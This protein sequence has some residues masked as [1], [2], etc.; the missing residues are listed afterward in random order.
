[1]TG[2]FMTDEEAKFC[3]Y[4]GA[5]LPS[6]SSFCPECGSSVSGGANPY[7][8]AASPNASNPLDTVATF[9]LIYGIIAVILGLIC[10]LV[11]FAFDQ[12]LVDELIAQFPELEAEL[13]AWDV[14]L[15]RT[16]S[17]VAGI[18]SVASGGLAIVA[19]GNM[20]NLVK[21]QMTFI[22]MILSSILS[23]GF[24]FLISVAIG[25]IMCYFV[26]KNKDAFSS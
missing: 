13:S 15:M 12:S 26:Y 2:T 21:W 17:I 16:E 19:Y 22:L 9:T 3:A 14:G 5:N 10:V 25:L 4:C 1:M 20:K 18:L 23:I 8:P 11:G 7:R 6:G 24:I